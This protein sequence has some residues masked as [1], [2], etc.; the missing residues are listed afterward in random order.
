MV[1]LHQFLMPGRRRA[2]RADPRRNRVTDAREGRW[3]GMTD[4]RQSAA[5]FFQ[6]NWR[7]EAANVWRVNRHFNHQT[8]EINA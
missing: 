2:D 7:I 4:S 3:Y 8:S 1:T 6:E 5:V